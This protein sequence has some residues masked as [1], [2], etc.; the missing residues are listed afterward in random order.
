MTT[1]KD[2][3]NR[4][5]LNILL[6]KPSFCW[7]LKMQTGFPLCLWFTY[8]FFTQGRALVV[9]FQRIFIVVLNWHSSVFIWL[10]YP[11]HNSF[12]CKSSGL[13]SCVILSRCQL[14]T[15]TGCLLQTHVNHS[16][17]NIYF[18][19][20]GRWAA[21]KTLIKVELTVLCFV[22]CFSGVLPLKILSYFTGK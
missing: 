5:L 1:N 9:L 6:S 20:Y 2:S 21:Y 17:E 7:Q 10:F 15:S 22:S 12:K 18:R 13:C 16:S 19:P 11:W 3:E 4:L 8:N 14:F